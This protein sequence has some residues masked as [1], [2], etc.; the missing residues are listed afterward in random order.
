MENPI[1]STPPNSTM[2]PDTIGDY[3]ERTGVITEIERIHYLE[4]RREKN[5]LE[6]VTDDNLAGIAI[7]GGGIRAATLGL[8]MLQSMIDAG[9]LKYF[10]YL[11][12]VSGGGYIGSCLTSLMSNEPFFMDKKGAIKNE[13]Y[14]FSGDMAGLDKENAPFAD[15]NPGY[16]Y[17]ALEE[18]RL[19]AKHQIKHLRQHGEYITLNKSLVGWDVRRAIGALSTGIVLNILTFIMVVS[20]VVLIHHVLFAAMSDNQFMSALRHPDKPLNAEITARY[21]AQGITIPDGVLRPSFDT[22][23]A[24]TWEEM[25]VQERL[26]MWVQRKIAQQFELIGNSLLAHPWIALCFFGLGALIG[27]VFLV[28]SR[29]FPLRIIQ[30]ECQEHAFHK[31][32]DPYTDRPGQSDAESDR[33]KNFK[34]W[35]SFFGFVVGP[36]LAYLVTMCLYRTGFFDGYHYFV[37]LA[38]PVCFALG[39]YGSVLLLSSF[40]FI[41]QAPERVSGR[42]YRS[43]YH[44]IQGTSVMAILVAISLPLVIILLF[45]R[46]GLAIKLMLSLIPVGAAYYFTLQSLGSKPGTNSFLN[47]VAQRL[48]LPLL[49][50]SLFLV[51]GMTFAWMSKLLYMLETEME[52]QL[53]ISLLIAALYALAVT[54]I[55]VLIFGF[56]INANDIALHYFYRDRLSEAYLRTNGRAERPEVKDKMRDDSLL[57]VNLRNHDQLRLSEVGEGNGRGPYHIILGALNLQGSNDLAK[58]TLK[59]DHFIFSKYFIGSRTTG[60]YRTDRYKDNTTK[61]STAMAIS[62][63]A[64]SAGMGSMGFAASNFYMTLLNFR[65]GYWME[66]PLFLQREK[67]AV[68]AEK[69]G[70]KVVRSWRQNWDKK[71]PKFPFWLIY[72]FDELTGDLDASTRRV[73]VSDGGHTGDNLSI[74]PLIQR[75]CKTIV[76]GDFEEDSKF[77]FVS[78]NQAVRLAKSVYDVDIEIDLRPLVPQKDEEGNLRSAESVVFGKITYKHAEKDG[79]ITYSVGQLVYMK[80]TVNLIEKDPPAVEPAPVYV[81][82]YQKTNPAFPHDSTADL[83]FDEV[84]FEA[85]RQLGAHI[86]AQAAAGIRMEGF[87]TLPSLKNV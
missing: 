28:Y 27:A 22:I 61:L 54:I 73:Y 52:T 21:A 45:G 26:F 77:H 46:H 86:G 16:N 15:L 23:P 24:A 76:V 18:T 5:G 70:Q 31:K 33:A 78:F 25:G 40:Y 83:Y 13:N 43:F 37:M 9:K 8:G 51:T 10:D 68:K 63:G 29:R 4:Q 12:T 2:L 50:L 87:L 62:A 81:L 67:E 49:N 35:F 19:T 57:E 64:V 74:L 80:S 32:N 44:G 53:G 72:L 56:A 82:N 3:I 71:F 39:L 41:N 75:K 14:R 65:T 48:R 11:S 66:N 59:S 30:Q 60:Y 36:L 55:A 1:P 58:K 79:T 7:S 84:Q 38:L 17:K 85:Y 34:W 69:G 20:V 42:L 6:P 47:T